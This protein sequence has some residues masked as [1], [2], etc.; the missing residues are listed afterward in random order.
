M[1]SSDIVKA[2]EVG[3]DSFSEA[4]GLAVGD[5]CAGTEAT[6]LGSEAVGLTVGD[7]CAGREA[8]GL[9]EEAGVSEVEGVGDG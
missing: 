6:G 5:A 9:D 4:I 7:T 8:T 2:A 3:G 1:L